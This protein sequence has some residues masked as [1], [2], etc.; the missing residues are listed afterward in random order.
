MSQIAINN[1]IKSP[2]NFRPLG[3]VNTLGPQIGAAA[4][5]SKSSLSGSIFDQY[6]Q[7]LQNVNALSPTNGDQ[8]QK[9]EKEIANL[10]NDPQTGKP[11][12]NNEVQQLLTALMAMLAGL[13]GNQNKEAASDNNPAV[14][15]VNVLNNTA[16][17]AQVNKGATTPAKQALNNAAV[18]DQ[19]EAKVLAGAQA[20]KAWLEGETGN[21]V[22]PQANA[23]PADNQKKEKINQTMKSKDIPVNAEDLGGN[24]LGQTNGSTITI[25]KKYAERASVGEIASTV[26][27]EMHHI[28]F[29]GGSQ[30]NEIDS[31]KFAESFR[32]QNDIGK[33]EADSQI[34]NWAKQNYAELPAT[35]GRLLV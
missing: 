32:D 28:A 23:E 26:L 11:I 4:P 10:E 21:A 15:S 31:E 3:Q 5:N 12:E 33:F 7:K 29:G 20:A 25:D 8:F 22:K 16:P 1:S 14:S 24:I 35:G 13:L 17:I 2:T 18:N 30:Q 19:A 34:S 27:H 9:I 6:S